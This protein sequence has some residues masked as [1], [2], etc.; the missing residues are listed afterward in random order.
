MSMISDSYH[1]MF[2]Q[3]GRNPNFA[4]YSYVISIYIVLVDIPHFTVAREGQSCLCEETN[5][6][7]GIVLRPQGKFLFILD[8][9]YTVYTVCKFCTISPFGLKLMACDMREALCKICQY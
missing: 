2:V 8:S 5:I 7:T 6:S 4:E 9:S 1:A 3:G